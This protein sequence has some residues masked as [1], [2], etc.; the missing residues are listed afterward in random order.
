MKK[1][2]AANWKMNLTRAQG[3][4]VAEDLSRHVQE[5]NNTDLLICP[6]YLHIAEVA[7]YG[8]PVGAQDC[9]AA[10][11]G[12]FT[13]D[14]SAEMLKDAGC[15][16]VIVGHSERRANHGEGREILSS[17][18]G[19]ARENGLHIIYCVGEDKSQRQEGMAEKIVR[20][21]MDVV[22][23]FDMTAAELS[24]A[25]EP[26]WAIGTGISAE[27]GDIQSMHY[28]IRA[29]LKEKLENAEDFRILYGGSLKPGNADEILSIPN[30]DGGLIGGASLKA[31][32]FLS[33]AKSAEGI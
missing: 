18:I 22:L 31:D 21:Q 5:F 17:K 25:Y 20:H 8:L 9:A 6:S 1:L 7:G 14:V 33:I 23:E 12:A 15:E 19:R 11:N 24:I 29:L 16:A 4:T 32:D 27:S 10:R 13:G 28:F 3:K 30:V 26:V 2:I